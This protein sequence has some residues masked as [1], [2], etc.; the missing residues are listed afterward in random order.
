[1]TCLRVSSLLPLLSAKRLGP[2]PAHVSHH[3]AG[4]CSCYGHVYCCW[5]SPLVVHNM[6]CWCVPKR[7]S[8]SV[9]HKQSYTNDYGELFRVSGLLYHL[10]LFSPCLWPQS[11]TQIGPKTASAVMPQAL[12]CIIAALVPRVACSGRVG[13]TSGPEL[14]VLLCCPTDLQD[15]EDSD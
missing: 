12:F 10:L 15:S 3:V 7:L 9:T 5:C 8:A 2:P 11:H 6:S 4:V 13:D 14:L 1:V